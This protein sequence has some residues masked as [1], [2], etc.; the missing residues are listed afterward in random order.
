MYRS[1]TYKYKDLYLSKVEVEKITDDILLKLDNLYSLDKDSIDNIE[2]FIENV[3]YT[4]LGKKNF[5]E[6]LSYTKYIKKD[7]LISYQYGL[8]SFNI[9]KNSIG[10]IYC[11]LSLLNLKLYNQANHL[12]EKNKNYIIDI[13][14]SNKCCVNDAINILIYFKLPITYIDDISYKLEIL[15]DLRKKYIYILLN[16]IYDRKNKLKHNISKNDLLEY[17]RDIL[18]ILNELKLNDLVKIVKLKIDSIL[19]EEKIDINEFVSCDGLEDFIT[20]T[21]LNILELDFDKKY[22]P[23]TISKYNYE[24]EFIKVISYKSKSLVNMHI[25]R[26]EDN[27]LVIDCGCEIISKGSRKI[28]IDNFFEK[29]NIDKNKIK[30]IIITHAHLDHYGSIDVIEKYVDN[31]YMTKDTLNI[32]KSIDK[33]I[34]NNEEKIKIKNKHE[35]F[36]I[37]DLEIEFFPNNHIKGSV[38]VFIKYKGKKI[39]H[40]SDFSFNEQLTTTYVDNKYFYKYRDCDYLIMESTYGYK[41]IEIPYKYKKYILSYFVNLSYKNGIKVII[42]TFAIGKSQECFNIIKNNIKDIKVIV[43]GLATRVN[44]CYYK[45]TSNKGLSYEKKK[46]IYNKYYENDVIIATGGVLSKGSTSYD[47]YDIAVND[48]K[49]V[50]IIKNGYMDKDTMYEK[51]KIYDSIKINVLDISLCFHADYSDLVLMIET[52]KPKNLILVHGEGIN[53]YI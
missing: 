22:V 16:V 48:N 30:D 1:N 40:T 21:I 52:I 17:S 7:Y 28:D 18:N 34:L 19:N 32:I 20:Y 38:G 23:N 44:E 3:L 6:T 12:F 49:I 37:K 35:K 47:Y 42:P 11:I 4:Q 25:I 27:Y 14:N 31:I 13:I 46:S 10:I 33:S 53:G 41:D 51:L 36:K 50:T 9:D 45:D 29:N 26:L 2:N 43:D 24:D 39:V 15:K 5:L 8:E